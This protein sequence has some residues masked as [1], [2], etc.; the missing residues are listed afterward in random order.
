[1]ATLTLNISTTT[2]HPDYVIPV[3]TEQTPVQRRAFELLGVE[4]Q[5]FV[6]MKGTG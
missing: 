1:M 2:G 5:K 6:A 4:P 3:V